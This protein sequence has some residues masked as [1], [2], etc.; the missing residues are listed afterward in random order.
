MINVQNPPW[1]NAAY[2]LTI[3][4]L[5]STLSFNSRCE[6]SL[7]G[8]QLHLPCQALQ[9]TIKTLQM[10]SEAGVMVV[11]DC[12]GEE[13]LISE[14]L[15][16]LIDILSPNETELARITGEMHLGTHTGLRV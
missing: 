10:A 9:N 4:A 16:Q 6:G 1:R 12:G 7:T 13:G 15:L 11:M 5:H 2:M 8:Q 14:K 3:S